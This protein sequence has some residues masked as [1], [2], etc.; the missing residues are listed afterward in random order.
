MKA[1]SDIICEMTAG[2]ENSTPVRLTA[3]GILEFPF[4][5][6]Q[7]SSNSL[8]RSQILWLDFQEN[9]P[10]L[11]LTNCAAMCLN[12]LDSSGEGRW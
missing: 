3:W 11:P 8:R 7:A 5:V 4:P 1:G 12:A 6:C 10:S 9:I 2:R